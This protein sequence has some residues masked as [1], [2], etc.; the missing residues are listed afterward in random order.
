MQL[1]RLVTIGLYGYD[2][3]SFFASLA[4][5]SVD[6]LCDVRRRRGVR[7]STYS[8][9]NS[10]R[11]QQRLR[12]LGIGYVHFRELA[13]TDPVRQ[14]QHRADQ[15]TGVSKRQR[16]RLSDAFVLAYTETCLAHLNIDA[17]LYQLGPDCRVPALFCVEGNPEACHRKILAEHLARL[18]GVE[19]QHLRP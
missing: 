10:T 5:A 2:E 19:V 4:S 8:F 16:Q 3:K 15:R 7:G 14:L 18:L 13:P 17:F 1:A 6:T 11:L 12:E 9:A